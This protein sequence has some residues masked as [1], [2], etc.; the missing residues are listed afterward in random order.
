[1]IS[2]VSGVSFGNNAIDLNRQQKYNK[3]TQTT[4]TQPAETPKKKG[5]AGKVIAWIVGLAA[6]GFI[7]LGITKGK[8]G[9]KWLKEVAAEGQNLNWKQYAKNLGHTVGEAAEKCWKYAAGLVNKAPKA[10]NEL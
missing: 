6:A 4:T 8:M 7:A 9:D 10:A 2:A 1:M 3:T 5:K